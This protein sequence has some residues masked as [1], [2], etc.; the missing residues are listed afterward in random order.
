MNVIFWIRLSL[1]K[2]KQRQ[3]K[4]SICILDIWT[5]KRTMATWDE[6]IYHAKLFG[7]FQSRTKYNMYTFVVCNLHEGIFYFFMLVAFAFWPFHRIGIIFLIFVCQSAQNNLSTWSY[8]NKCRLA[9]LTFFP[10]PCVCSMYAVFHYSFQFSLVAENG[11]SYFFSF[12]CHHIMIH[13][14]FDHKCQN[15]IQTHKVHTRRHTHTHQWTMNTVKI[16]Y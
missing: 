16:Q 11:F 1:F 14:T 5:I 15:D 13:S 8:A 7:K 12:R 3:H 6:H 4:T 2:E 10:V 9:D